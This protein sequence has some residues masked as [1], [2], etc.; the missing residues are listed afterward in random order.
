[1][2]SVLF[3]CVYCQF[4]SSDIG[5]VVRSDYWVQSKIHTLFPSKNRILYSLCHQQRAAKETE[6]CGLSKGSIVMELNE[7][8][9][10]S[11]PVLKKG[12]QHYYSCGVIQ[13]ICPI[14]D[15]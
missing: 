10:F 15:Y 1:M 9:R 13:Q 5:T 2:L 14:H 3:T 8:V 12:K 4:F 7:A 11:A 6:M